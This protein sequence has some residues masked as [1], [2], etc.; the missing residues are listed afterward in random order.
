MEKKT[1]AIILI[2]VVIGATILLHIP[3]FLVGAP[4]FGTLLPIDSLT[5][6]LVCI[7]VAAI[8][9][10]VIMYFGKIRPFKEA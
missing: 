9:I 10:I 2:I 7:P 5:R 3:R 8:I 1:L 6:H 4:V